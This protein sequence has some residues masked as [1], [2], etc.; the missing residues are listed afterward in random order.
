MTTIAPLQH[1]AGGIPAHSTTTSTA[2]LRRNAS[3]R[4]RAHPS[5]GVDPRIEALKKKL[6]KLTPADLLGVTGY[7]TA[8]IRLFAKRIAAG[9]A[10]CELRQEDWPAEVSRSYFDIGHTDHC[11]R[12]LLSGTDFDTA[13]QREGISDNAAVSL[14]F[15]LASLRTH[16]VDQARRYELL[17]A[18]WRKA[19]EFWPE[20]AK[21]V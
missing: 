1:R 4:H 19:G 12:A 10:F 11:L 18:M 9:V 8:D 3:T 6:S 21:A 13:C 17:T 5:S 20:C 7:Q 15:F 2:G 16:R 14:G